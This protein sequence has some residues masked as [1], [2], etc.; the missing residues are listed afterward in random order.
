MIENKHID[1]FTEID[2]SIFM[3]GSIDPMGLR[4]LWT[5][6]GSN[7]FGNKLNTIS[8]DI[9]LYTINLF[10]HWV[11]YSLEKQFPEKIHRIIGTEAYPGRTDFRE[12]VV[13]F[14]E[15]LLVQSIH[16]L[17]QQLIQDGQSSIPGTSKLQTLINNE[18]KNATK[19]E[20]N[21]YSGILVRH[22]QLG[23]HRRHKGPFIQMDI[24]G[25][26]DYYFNRVLWEQ[27]DVLFNSIPQWRNLKLELSES[28]FAPLFDQK[29]SQKKYYSIN[30][31]DTP[32]SSI[33]LKKYA[34]ILSPENFK[35]EL[36]VHFWEDRIGLNTGPPSNLYNSLKDYILKRRYLNW[37]NIIRDSL[38]N[39]DGDGREKVEAIV[40]IEP[41]LALIGKVSNKLLDKR[42]HSTIDEETIGFIN[43]KIQTVN[44]N[45]SEIK[46]YCDKSFY[47]QEGLN[48]ILAL[49]YIYNQQLRVPDATVF[50]ES[51]IDYHSKLMRDRGGLPWVSID[52]NHIIKHHRS[53]YFNEKQLLDL[54]NN[55]WVNNY[56][57]TT[58]FNLYKGLHS[59]HEN[60]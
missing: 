60:I 15:C 43:H 45:I 34:Q 35:K 25:N 30:T 27:V 50:C 7:I 32:I 53:L 29:I 18:D 31:N 3:D 4:I 28:V 5:S 47:D 46:K 36:I 57:L 24:F 39:W 33:I 1:I 13:I 59:G 44:L 19:V 38:D 20:V 58:L 2:D 56:Y 14:L 49:I 10:H 54:F 16:K 51:L 12:G 48:R 23:I 17:K 41:F 42:T 22:L 52:S 6:L 21:K 40:A 55:N 37:E 9:R 26:K 8:N 11:I